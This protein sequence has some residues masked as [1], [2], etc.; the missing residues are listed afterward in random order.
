VRIN[1]QREASFAV[2]L[3]KNLRASTVPLSSP[4]RFSATSRTLLLRLIFSI[5]KLPEIISDRK[6]VLPFFLYG[7]FEHFLPIVLLK[8]C[9][10]SRLS[11]F[12]TVLSPLLVFLCSA[13]SFSSSLSFLYPFEP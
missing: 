10:M 4:T 1:G 9:T 2:P 7:A 11:L 3:F 8:N 12:C 5:L 6:K 13:S